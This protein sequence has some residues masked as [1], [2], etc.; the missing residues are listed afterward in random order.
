MKSRKRFIKNIFLGSLNQVLPN[1]AGLNDK[2][3]AKNTRE[4]I[5]GE[6][7]YI[8]T[9]PETAVLK[10]TDSDNT[11]SVFLHGSIYCLEAESPIVNAT[12][13]IEQAQQKEISHLI[14]TD[15]NGSF[16]IQLIIAEEMTEVLLTASSPYHRSKQQQINIPPYLSESDSTPENKTDRCMFIDFFLEER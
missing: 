2:S 13:H 3:N 1:T 5:L 11:S 12:I 4:E 6:G 15:T 16:S 10:F 9:P 14:Y 8:P 7:N